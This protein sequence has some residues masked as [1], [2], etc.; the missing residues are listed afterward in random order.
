MGLDTVTLL[1]PF[2]QPRGQSQEETSVPKQVEDEMK[3]GLRLLDHATVQDMAGMP[4][5]PHRALYDSPGGKGRPKLVTKG[6]ESF[7]EVGL[8]GPR[9]KQSQPTW[10]FS[11]EDTDS[12]VPNCG[13]PQILK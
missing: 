1:L 11:P 8:P 13:E 12:K 3:S 2:L 9:G 6:E 4:W 5:A 10:E 7:L